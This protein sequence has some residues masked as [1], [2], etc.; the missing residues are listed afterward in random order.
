MDT[1][2]LICRIKFC[3]I[4]R[5]LLGPI[6]NCSMMSC[7]SDCWGPAIA[8]SCDDMLDGTAHAATSDSILRKSLSP[9]AF[10]QGARWKAPCCSSVIS[11]GIAA[12]AALVLMRLS[13]AGTTFLFG[14][15]EGRL[16]IYINRESPAKHPGTCLCKLSPRQWQLGT[17]RF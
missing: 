2:L 1:N 5:T 7:T 14:L 13:G 4:L 12:N 9:L 17:L 16:T 15:I 3:V 8:L 11:P 6:P 10:D